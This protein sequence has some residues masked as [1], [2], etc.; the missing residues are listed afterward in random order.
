VD[1][2][3][4]RQESVGP[5]LRTCGQPI[6]P[7][8]RRHSHPRSHSVVCGEHAARQGGWRYS[9]SPL[10]RAP[11]VCAGSGKHDQKPECVSHASIRVIDCTVEADWDRSSAGAA[12]VGQFQPLEVFAMLFKV[13]FQLS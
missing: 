11:P 9:L 12:A 2:L 7:R 10:V 5:F 1:E 13:V 8:Q 4:V 3:P 6:G